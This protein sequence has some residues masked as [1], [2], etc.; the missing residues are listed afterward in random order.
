MNKM[1]TANKSRHETHS[2]S[3]STWS[4]KFVRVN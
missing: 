4:G 2:S 3:H 1:I